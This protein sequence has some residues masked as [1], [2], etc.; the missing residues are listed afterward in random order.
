MD[1]FTYKAALYCA[2]CVK[3]AMRADRKAAFERALQNTSDVAGI[4]DSIARE[5]GFDP[6]DESTW[7][8]DD[9][10][11]GPV[12]DGGG[13]ADCAQHCDRCGRFL[14]NPLTADGAEHVIDALANPE[15]GD[16]E[17]LLA[18]A[19][20]YFATAG[21][22]T[23]LR[24]AAARYLEANTGR[25]VAEGARVGG[26][27][28]KC[29]ARWDRMRRGGTLYV[30]V[31][32]V[33]ATKG[34]RLNESEPEETDLTT[35]GEVYRFA[36]REYGRCQ[37]KVYVDGPN[38]KAK[39]VGWCF[40]KRQKYEDCDETFLM[41]TWVTLHDGPARKRMETFQHEVNGRNGGA[42]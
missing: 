19:L 1:A 33:N 20:H 28:P 27:D 24:D 36:T 14:Q 18:W 11:K 38:G 25:A 10:P 3:A 6:A 35:A 5:L 4:R 26:M 22:K 32:H 8:S 31:A 23:P 37:S 2:T 9:L 17:T 12:A 40:V 39:H 30:E 21:L 13:E 29:V 7:D 16:E 42:R 15:E 41:E 34:W